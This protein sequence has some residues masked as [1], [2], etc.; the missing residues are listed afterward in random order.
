MSIKENYIRETLKAEYEKVCDLRNS[1]RSTV[2][3]YKHLKSGEKLLLITTTVQNDGV[4]KVLK[5]EKHENLPMIYDVCCGEN[6]MLVIEEFVEGE[7]LANIISREAL[8][9]KRAI[10]YC[11]DVCEALKQLHSKKIIHRD[12]KPL[13]VIIDKQDNAVLIDL[14]SSRLMSDEKEKDTQYLGTVGYAAPEQFGIFQSVPATDIYALGV[15]FNELLIG[16]HPSVEIPKG[17][18]G[19]IVGKCT[20]IN[21]PKR[22][23]SVEAL[24]KDLKKLY[25]T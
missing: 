4:F 6:E 9:K 20:N 10:K 5:G 18:L 12:I 13:N 23:Q 2:A 1:K 25:S 17:R 7:N 8:P 19:K 22:Y 11:L 3:S 24:Q 14:Q 15:M 21:I 16:K